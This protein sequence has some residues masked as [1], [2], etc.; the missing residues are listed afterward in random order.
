MKEVK[1]YE[2]DDGRL[3]NEE[4]K[5]TNYEIAKKVIAELGKILG[6]PYTLQLNSHNNEILKRIFHKREKLKIFLVQSF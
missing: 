2:T 6:T 1:K 3:F 5:A 4:W